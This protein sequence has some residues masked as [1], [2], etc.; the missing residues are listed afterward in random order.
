MRESVFSFGE[1]S[2]GFREKFQSYN[3]DDFLAAVKRA[4]NLYKDQ[5]E[6]WKALITK[7]MNMDFS[8]DVPAGRYMELFNHMLSW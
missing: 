8:W 5:P 6:A 4:L 1:A 7:E 3:A 2:R